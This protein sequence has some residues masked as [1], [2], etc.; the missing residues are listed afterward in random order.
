M[1]PPKIPGTACYL[2][3]D[4]HCSTVLSVVLYIAVNAKM[5]VQT[6]SKIGFSQHMPACERRLLAQQL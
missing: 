3:V 6:H 1:A 4:I 5:H 2:F